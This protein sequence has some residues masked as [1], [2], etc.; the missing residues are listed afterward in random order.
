[1]VGRFLLC[2]Y[3]KR[4]DFSLLTTPLLHTGGRPLFPVILIA[5]LGPLLVST[6]IEAFLDRFDSLFVETTRWVEE[7]V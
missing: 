2:L 5:P 3:C 6:T 7:S 1:M 4:L